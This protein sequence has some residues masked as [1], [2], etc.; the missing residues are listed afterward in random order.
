[1]PFIQIQVRVSQ[2]FRW[3]VLS[4][5]GGNVDEPGR[6][7]RLVQSW[8]G[9]ERFGAGGDLTVRTGGEDCSDSDP[10]Q[11]IRSARAVGVARKVVR[12]WAKR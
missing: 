9:L 12:L 2:L 10:G 11:W 6:N 1:M 4:L 5:T 7:A 8:E 3:C